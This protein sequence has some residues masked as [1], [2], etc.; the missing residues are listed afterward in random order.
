MAITLS[1]PKIIEFM[2]GTQLELTDQVWEN[3]LLVVE[4]NRTE[5]EVRE[6]F[7]KEKF[8]EVEF[9][10]I[11]KTGQ[12]GSGLIRKIG[13]WQIH[14]RLFPHDEHIQI[15]AEAELSNDYVEHLTHGWISAFKGSWEVLMKHF[16]ELWVYHK[17][18]GKYV[19]R[20]IKEELL[21]LEEPKSK[22]DVIVLALTLIAVLAIG[23]VA[24]SA[25]RK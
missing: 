11:I 1:Y 6:I 16:G 19:S 3:R 15:D 20:V 4:T 12:L 23:F 18:V 2:D 10:E 25:L 5:K 17:G 21:T 13:D 22:T 9:R 24:A 14:V 8:E 7:H